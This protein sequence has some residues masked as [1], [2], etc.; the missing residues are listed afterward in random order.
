M[1]AAISWLAGRPEWPAFTLLSTLSLLGL[2]V[3]KEL[4]I[5]AD[6][7]LALRISELLNTA[8]FLLIAVFGLTLVVTVT[9]VLARGG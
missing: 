3:L 6:T 9:D 7:P 1:P 5:S 4:C 2:L 8:I